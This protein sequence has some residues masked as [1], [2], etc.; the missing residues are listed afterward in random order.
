MSHLRTLLWSD[1]SEPSFESC[2]LSETD[3]GFQIKGVVVL[4]VDD[5]PT[6]IQYELTID[7]NWHTQRVEVELTQ[8]EKTFSLSLRVDA[9]KRWWQG[10]SELVDCRGCLDVDLSFSPSTNTL[11]MRRLALADG[12]MKAIITA[13]VQLPDLK[14]SPFPQQYTRHASGEYLFTSL[15]DDFKA[16]L[17]VDDLCLVRDYE[18]L[19]QSIAQTPR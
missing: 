13:W 5:S 18:G 17:L 3:A 15:K 14:V 8:G 16:I 6:S 1:R 9:E 7:S 19:W 12:E 2:T 10:E 11:A 4:V